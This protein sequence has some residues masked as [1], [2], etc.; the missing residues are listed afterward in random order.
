[1]SSSY[2][3]RLVYATDDG[4][5]QEDRSLSALGASG[6]HSVRLGRMT[7]L[8]DG[9][10]VAL[11][12]GC[13]PLGMDEAGHVRKSSIPSARPVS[14][15]LPTGYTRLLTPEYQKEPGVAAM[16][17]FGYTA[18]ASL[19][20]KLFAAAMPL[21]PGGA[22]D[23]AGHNTPDLESIVQSRLHAEPTNRLLAQAARRVP[24]GR[25]VR[26]EQQVLLAP[27]DQPAPQDRPGQ[28]AQ[29]GEAGAEFPPTRSV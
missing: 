28:M 18:V 6:L 20:G 11:L 2:R 15:L 29:L 9:A 14:A 25:R 10:T 16:P 1:M 21:D 4:E 19:H 5:L 23:P 27:L 22:W 7:P 17:L 12:P 3:W 24:R 8:P 13:T 26:L